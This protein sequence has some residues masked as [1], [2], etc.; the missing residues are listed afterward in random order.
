MSNGEN[1]FKFKSIKFLMNSYKHLKVNLPSYEGDLK[2]QNKFMHAGPKNVDKYQ[3]YMT[4]T[5]TNQRQTIEK[6][7]NKYIRTYF[8]KLKTPIPPSA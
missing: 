4:K 2:S 6:V 7:E 1:D 5:I 8:N 3:G